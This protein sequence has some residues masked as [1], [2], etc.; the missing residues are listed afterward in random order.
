MNVNGTDDFDWRLEYGI[1]L[2][3]GTGPENDHTIGT[4]NGYYIYIETSYPAV[5]G[6]KAHF[7]S[8]PMVNGNDGCMLFWYH[9]FGKVN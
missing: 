2:T 8:E 1:T 6:W 5:K 3:Y 7:V 4:Y 9:M